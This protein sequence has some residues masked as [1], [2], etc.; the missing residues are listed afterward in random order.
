MEKPLKVYPALAVPRQAD[1]KA[2][3]GETAW[4]GSKKPR[5]IG[6]GSDMPTSI[7][8]LFAKEL[9][10]SSLGGKANDD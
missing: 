10:E 7:W 8:S 6:N 2:G 5:P 4:R 3:Q 1:R 9:T